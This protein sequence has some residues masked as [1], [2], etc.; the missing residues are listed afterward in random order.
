M[1]TLYL[2]R[3][4]EASFSG[5]TDKTRMLTDQGLADAAALGSRLSD[6]H[7]SF[8]LVLCSAAIRTRQTFKAL[9]GRMHLA[10]CEIRYLEALYNA[11]RE[12]Y[13]TEANAL[14]DKFNSVLMIGHNP[15]IFEFAIYLASSQ[16]MEHLGRLSMGYSPCSL[17]GFECPIERWR[18]LSSQSNLLEYYAPH[19]M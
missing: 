16:N 10:D 7:I 11:P 8:D 13:L 2:L 1:K 18:D 12:Q 19:E 15:G 17:T 5:H 14:D 4:A 9:S 6:D 3:H